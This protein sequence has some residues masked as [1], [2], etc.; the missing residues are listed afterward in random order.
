MKSFFSLPDEIL[1]AIIDELDNQRDI[2]GFGSTSRHY[3]SLSKG[4][5]FLKNRLKPDKYKIV[6]N[7]PQLL[8][9]IQKYA[10]EDYLPKE[11]RHHPY[12]QR[13]KKLQ[14]IFKE[15][16]STRKKENLFHELMS[17]KIAQKL[18]FWNVGLY[19]IMH[20]EYCN[21]LPAILVKNARQS[22][23]NALVYLA[24]ENLESMLKESDGF[25]I[26]KLRHFQSHYGISVNDE[27]IKDFKDYQGRLFLAFKELAD[28]LQTLHPNAIT[29][30]DDLLK[31]VNSE[32][33][34]GYKEEKLKQQAIENKIKAEI[35]CFYPHFNNYIDKKGVIK[36]IASAHDIECCFTRE[37]LLDSLKTER[38]MNNQSVIPFRVK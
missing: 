20:K 29:Y 38:E 34:E 24:Q 11:K 7:N 33:W 5:A 4:G 6:K 21:E 16:I 31:I 15:R 23:E 1:L 37:S 25:A 30:F 10:I 22:L 27:G 17:D 36:A 28:Y 35:I 18:I 3:Y 2:F 26:V 13:Y 9:K 19:R 8:S 12:Y 32:S 14:E